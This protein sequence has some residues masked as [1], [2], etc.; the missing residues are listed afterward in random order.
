M[1]H[2]RNQLTIGPRSFET[3]SAANRFLKDL[4]YSQPLK[5]TIQEP[6]HAFLS[7]LISRHPRAEDIVG[8]GIDHFTAENSVRGGRC[9]CM[10]RVDGT[11]TDFSFFDC[12]RGNE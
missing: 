4:L 12:V 2:R 8:K 9:F 1:R 11:Q 5:V 7:A 3:R 6:H 10:T